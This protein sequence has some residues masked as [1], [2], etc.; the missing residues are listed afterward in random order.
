MNENRQDI[1]SLFDELDM[2]SILRDVLRNLWVIIL[3]ALAVGMIVNMSVRA[4]Y[5]STYSTTATFVVTSKNYSNYAYSNLNA[6]NTMADSFSNILNS[7]LLRKKVCQ[8]LG[9]ASFNATTS[10]EVINGTNLMTLHVTSDT[11][12]NTYRITRSIMN[13][14]TGLTHYVSD[15]MVMEVLQE[16]A[17]PTKADASFTAMHQM[18]RASVLAVLAFSAMFMYLSYRKQTIKGEKDLENKLDAKCLGM[19]YKESKYSS[20]TAFLRGRKNKYLITDLT[21]RFEFVE[22]FK[23]IGARVLSEAKKDGAKVILVSSVLEHEGK[24]TVAANLALTLSQ[25]SYK[26]LLIDGDLRR[27]TQQKLFLR[28]RDKMKAGLGELLKDKVSLG[29]ALRRDR[30][31]GIHLLLGEH[32]YS[33]STDIV[34]SE[35][36]N[37]LIALVREYYDYVIIDSPPMSLM[38][39]AEVLANLSDMS[40][41]VVEYDRALAEDLNDAIDSLR[42]CKAQFAGC[43]L[44]EVRTMPTA[45]RVIGGYGGYG[46][47]GNYGRYGRYGDYGRYGRYGAYGAYGRSAQSSGSKS[48]AA[49]TSK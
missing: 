46:H 26:V 13:N 15:N 49:K 5:Q 37:R 11:P 48:T 42:D 35:N 8:D 16:P 43:I 12:Y 33:N 1:G 23:K 25:Q 34:S 9:V 38:A 7:S 18:M 36:M 14:I 47:Y 39:D 19:L 40:L 10:A 2:F 4:D 45:R 17:V 28:P 32:N 22:R 3:G 24:S 30:E 27:P 21:A 44:N 29:D 31:R 41:L 6:A 20:F